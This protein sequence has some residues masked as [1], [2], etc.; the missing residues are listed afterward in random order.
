MEPLSTRRL[1]IIGASLGAAYGLL[2]R[3]VFGF[4]LGQNGVFEVMSVAFIF[5]VP[6]ALGFITVWFGESR[7]KIPWLRCIFAPWIAALLCLVC[8]LT[9]VWEGIICI[10][11]WL[12][13]FLLLS[14]LGGVIAGIL[15]RILRTARDR[16]YCV[17]AIALLPFAV[18]PLEKLNS[19]NSEI[20]TVNTEIKIHA[21][22]RV[23]WNQIKTVPVIQ[24]GEHSYS[25][26]HLLGFPRPL[27]A[28]LVGEGVG[29][30][31]Y[32][33]FERGVLFV[34]TIT[35]WDELK[36]LSFSIR[37]DTEH[38]PPATFD[39]HVTI[40]GRYFDV[41]DGGYRLETKSDG[42]VILHLASHQRLSTR[43]NF[44]SHLWTE[45][46]MSD[47]QNYILKIIKAR[48]EKTA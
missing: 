21:P 36:K 13:L 1:G 14:S 31:R 2:A 11:I 45:G 43:F 28:K 48:C 23:V 32:A 46:L 39:E 41:L 25:F 18:A 27:E 30:V 33:T 10:V 42:D 3:L 15:H 17:A 38:I 16:N 40:G 8:A 24:K 47:L 12:P 34:E 44:Y 26:S 37:A 9:L 7:N 22:A 19:T 4:H 29:A 20:H 35:E 6:V 5:G